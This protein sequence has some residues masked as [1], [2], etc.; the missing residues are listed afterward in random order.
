MGWFRSSPSTIQFVQTLVDRCG[1]LCDDQIVMNSILAFDMGMDWN[2]TDWHKSIL[3]NHTIDSQNGLLKHGFTGVSNNTGHK[4]MIW[5]RDFA[6]RGDNDPAICPV[7]NWVSMPYV[8]AKGGWDSV[9]AK[10]NSY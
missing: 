8:K 9:N 1:I 6:F 10:L 2:V 5:D 7:D 4:V 3:T